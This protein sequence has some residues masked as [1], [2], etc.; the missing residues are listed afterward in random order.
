MGWFTPKC[1]VCSGSLQATGY[2]APYPSYRCLACIRAAEVKQLLA[3]RK[4]TGAKEADGTK[5]S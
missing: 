4:T 2:S 5:P 3:D 1:P